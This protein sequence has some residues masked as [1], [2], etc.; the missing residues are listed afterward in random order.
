MQPILDGAKDKV[1]AVLVAVDKD[2][3]DFDYTFFNGPIF[4]DT[5]QCGPPSVLLLPVPK[6]AGVNL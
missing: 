2:Q 4:T 5:D 1:L 3:Q 6:R